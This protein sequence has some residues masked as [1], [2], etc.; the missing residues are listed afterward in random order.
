[1]II[2]FAAGGASNFVGHA[3]WAKIVKDVGAVAE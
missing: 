3:F 2:P 1:M